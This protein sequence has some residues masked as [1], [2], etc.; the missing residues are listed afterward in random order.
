MKGQLFPYKDE[1]ISKSRPVITYLLI[2]LNV[3]IFIWS[4]TDFENIINTLGFLPAAPMFLTLFTSMFLHGGIDH[5]F[6]NMWFLFMFGDNVEDRFGR[7]KYIIF[8]LFAGLAATAAHFL[9]NIGSEIPTI[10][11]SGAIVGKAFYEGKI[12]LREAIQNVS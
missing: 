5:I 8:Y 11:A 1:N 4:L 7:V 10:G 9:T 6:G 2:A 12:S 3:I